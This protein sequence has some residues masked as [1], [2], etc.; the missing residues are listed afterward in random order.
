[1]KNIGIVLLAAFLTSACKV[2]TEDTSLQEKEIKTLENM[3]DSQDLYIALG[4]EYEDDLRKDLEELREEFEKIGI[5]WGIEEKDNP[6]SIYLNY[7]PSAGVDY[8][9]KVYPQKMEILSKHEPF[10]IEI[11]GLGK[12]VVE[13]GGGKKMSIIHFDVKAS[14]EYN[15]FCQIVQSC[16]E[17]VRKNVF[18]YEGPHATIA[19]KEGLGVEG[20]LLLDEVL[21]KYKEKKYKVRATRLVVIERREGKPYFFAKHDFSKPLVG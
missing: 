6:F 3:R 11:I 12:R 9:E 18:L 21:K 13:L 8:L 10:E 7:I 15:D 19:Y 4:L 1:M 16:F 5:P 2:E 20:G 17:D 14:G